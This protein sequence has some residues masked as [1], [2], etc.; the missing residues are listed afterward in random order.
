MISDCLTPNNASV[1]T[2]YL[3]TVVC[4]FRCLHMSHFEKFPKGPL[5]LV[6]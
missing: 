3:F 6:R 2:V 5:I 1:V 4:T